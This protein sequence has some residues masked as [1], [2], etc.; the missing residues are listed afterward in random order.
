MRIK[1]IGLIN[2]HLDIGLGRKSIQYQFSVLAEGTPEQV[3]D[4]VRTLFE[5]VG[6]EGGYILSCADHFF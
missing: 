4:Q 2:F 5:K 6:Y 3:H 1:P